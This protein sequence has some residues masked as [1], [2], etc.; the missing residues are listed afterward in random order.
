MKRFFVCALLF[1]G[2]FLSTGNAQGVN[3][4]KLSLKEAISKAKDPTNPRLVFVDCYTSWCVPCLEMAKNEFPKKIAGDFFNPKFVSVKY[5]MEKGEGID[6]KKKYNV[7]VY[8]TFLILNEKGEE[9]NRLVGKSGAEE[10]I[11]KVTKALDP[12]NSLAG[13]KATYEEKRDMLSGLPYAKALLENNQDPTPLLEELYDNGQDF[14][15]FS[16]DFTSFAMSTVKFGSPFFRKMMLEKYRMDEELGTQVV[17]QMI[18]D[19]IRKDMYIVA[20]ERTARY[21]ISYTPQEVEDIAYTI[22]LLKLDPSDPES[23]MCRVALY[24]A[25]NDLDGMISYY[26]RYIWNLPNNTV[27]KPILEG[28][29]MSNVAKATAEQKAGIKDYFEYAAKTFEKQAN[30]YKKQAETIK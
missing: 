21:K 5:D 3:F 4:E 27:Y 15:R 8:P 2:A 6:I 7:D 16:R 9:V 18:F 23:H 22:G 14:E 24:V 20:N 19:K 28:I 17:N 10:F 13:L 1:I 26:R 30:Y 25:K 29:L 12:K 11:E